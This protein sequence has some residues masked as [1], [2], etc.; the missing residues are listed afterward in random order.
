METGSAG[1]EGR[2]R[3]RVPD[4]VDFAIVGGGY[5]GLHT[6]IELARLEPGARVAVLER[7]RCGAGASGLNGGQVHSWWNQALTLGAICGREEAKRL[8]SES[9]TAID[10]I[11][12]LSERYPAIDF[13]QAGW[14]WTAST[15]AQADS[16]DACLAECAA[17]GVEPFAKLDGEDLR[18]RVGTDTICAGV[19]ERLGGTVDPQGLVDA[20]RA[21]AISFGVQVCEGAPVTG[22]EGSRPFSLSTPGGR[23]V[24]DAAILTTNAWAARH[25]ELRRF[26]YV[27]GSDIVLTDPLP[28]SP[29]E[30]LPEVGLAVCDSQAR[31]LYWS[32]LG[33][34]RLRFGRGGGR[35]APFNRLGSRVGEATRWRRDVIAE[36]RRIYPALPAVEPGTAW[37]GPIDRTVDGFPIFGTLGESG[38][39]YGVGWSGSGVVGS[40]LGGKI[41]ASLASERDDPWSRSSLVA[42]RPVP[43]P[44]EPLRTVGA[45][46]VRSAVR[47]ASKAE[48]SGRRPGPVT[49]LVAGL[50]PS[51]KPSPAAG[52]DREAQ[53]GGTR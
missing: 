5:V 30:D 35:I 50:T 29:G 15:P 8:A 52:H 3:S 37:S 34:R 22:I 48:L 23:I 24:A 18:R 39:W 4:R 38:P 43:L 27:V 51:L 21:E 25:P 16:W 19:V 49:R 14:L 6:A 20:L 33:D 31:V 40:V 11:R 44:P 17:Q 32:L 9:V 13:K 7:D 47:R 1:D 53:P 36:M 46:L 12:E 45:H 10:R 41:L 42:R 28:G 26:L 2:L